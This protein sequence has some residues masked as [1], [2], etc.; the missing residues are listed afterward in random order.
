ML[1]TSE[2]AINKSA[3]QLRRH[4]SSSD[5]YSETEVKKAMTVSLGREMDQY[6]LLNK[7]FDAGNQSEPT[8][9]L[10]GSANWMRAMAIKSANLADDPMAA[11]QFY[12]ERAKESRCSVDVGVQALE[13]YYKALHYLA[14]LKSIASSS[15]TYDLIRSAIIS[16]YYALYFASRAFVLPKSSNVSDTHT[17]V[18]KQLQHSVILRGLLISPFDMN[19]PSIVEEEFEQHVSK[20]Y[21]CKSFEL[22]Y[23]PTSMDAQSALVAYLRGTARY[24]QEIVK[25]ELRKTAEFKSL[26][27][28]NFKTK[29]ARTLRDEWLR[30]HH[31]NILVQA[32]RYRGKAN[33]RDGLYLSYGEDQ[34]EIMSRWTVDMHSV[35]RAFMVMLTTYLLHHVPAELWKEYCSDIKL[36]TR[37]NLDDELL[38][39]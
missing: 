9:A 4:W 1:L 12:G 39:Q 30:K 8:Y 14:A 20:N 26:Q 37:F 25:Q 10:L 5:T 36:H 38:I 24:R 27:V 2:L 17:K 34:V 3:P 15:N 6:W 11:M 13:N 35:A 29:K 16:W 7:L 32:F 19:A 22:I 31:V 21:P 33:Y 18:A 23:Q 28:D